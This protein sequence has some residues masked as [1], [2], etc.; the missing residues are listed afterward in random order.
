MTVLRAVIYVIVSVK[1]SLIN[2]PR[3]SSFSLLT[4]LIIVSTWRSSSKQGHVFGCRNNS[5]SANWRLQ[6]SL[7]APC[8]PSLPYASTPPPP[9]PPHPT[10]FPSPPSYTHFA[11][12]ARSIS[13]ISNFVWVLN[14]FWKQSERDRGREHLCCINKNDS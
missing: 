2:I 11:L 9:P 13:G 6:V 12:P 3:P 8:L 5:G 14:R 10:S 7:S 4:E 1:R